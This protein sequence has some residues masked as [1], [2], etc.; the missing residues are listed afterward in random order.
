[1]KF[2]RPTEAGEEVIAGEMLEMEIEIMFLLGCEM[3]IACKEKLRGN[4]STFLGTVISSEVFKSL[5]ILAR[6]LATT[7]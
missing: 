4:L 7:W 5:T 3:I 2:R 6:G 1:M